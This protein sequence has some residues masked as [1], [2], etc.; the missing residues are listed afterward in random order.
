MLLRSCP[1]PDTRLR[2]RRPGADLPRRRRRAAPP[3]APATVPAT[4]SARSSC[5]CGHVSAGICDCGQGVRARTFP[6]AGAGLRC[7]RRLAALPSAPGC[8]AVGAGTSPGDIVRAVVML[9]RSIL[10]RDMRLRSRRPGADLPRRR[11]LAAP[12]PGPVPAALSARSSCSCG[13]LSAWICSCGQGAR[14]RTLPAGRLA[15]GRRAP[16]ARTGLRA[17]GGWGPARGRL[18]GGGPARPG[19]GAGRPGCRPAPGRSGR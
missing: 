16:R 1:G 17:G 12:A 18:G 9:L 8:A 2:S 14:S 13:H 3:S 6:A 5:S 15:A 7:R 4:L 19:G 11:R 10:G